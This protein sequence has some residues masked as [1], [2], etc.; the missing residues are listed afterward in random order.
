MSEFIK[1][2]GEI[3][4]EEALNKALNFGI[5][6]V[7]TKIGSKFS[8][9]ISGVEVQVG[10]NITESGGETDE[11]QKIIKIDTKKSS[12]SLRDVEDL[13]VPQG[14]YD[15]G[16]LTELVP[17]IAD[18]AYSYSSY[19]IVH[20]LGHIVGGKLPVELSPTRYGRRATNEAFAEAFTY[21]VYNKPID[22]EAE[23]IIRK[24]L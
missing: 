21:W 18:Q 2:R 22:P 19:N 14:Y 24:K 7:R 8:E 23:T 5:E 13:L 11:K 15:T 9:V 3:V 17:S 12:M 4:D 6:Q 20:E 1:V 16:N 10:N